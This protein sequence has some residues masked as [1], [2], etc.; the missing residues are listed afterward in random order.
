MRHGVAG[1]KLGRTSS[2]RKALRTTLIR[3]LFEHEKITTTQAKA[4]AFRGDAEKLITLAKK[5]NEGDKV[6]KMNAAR[7]ASSRLG[8]DRAITEKLFNDIAPRF[9]SRNGGYTRMIKL[10]PRKGD[11]AEMVLIELVSE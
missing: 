11:S 9:K 10:G 3:Q 1:K 4:H 5:G 8:N 6:A 7:L 2:Q